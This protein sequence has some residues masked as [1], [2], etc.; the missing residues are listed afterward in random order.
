MEH[1][2]HTSPSSKTETKHVAES[3]QFFITLMD[4][5]KLNLVAVDQLHP[6]LVDLVQ[7][8][9]KVSLPSDYTGKEKFKEWLILLNKRKASDELSEEECRQFLFDLE[10]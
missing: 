7:S 2:I 5:L 3:V 8:L 10:R 6:Q 4:S 1:A 9:H